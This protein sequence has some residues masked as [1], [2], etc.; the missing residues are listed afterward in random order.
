MA[1][2][3][4]LRSANA[5]AAE[6]AHEPHVITYDMPRLVIGRG[7]GCDL[8]L[9]DLSVSH[10]HASIRQRGTEYI[11]MDEGSTNGTFIGSVRLPPQSPRVLR[12]GEL[13]RL[14]RVWLEVRVEYSP[15]SVQTAQAT[16]ELALALV[17]Q[18][19]D[20]QGRDAGPRLVVVDGP[21]AGKQLD[22]RDGNEQVVLGR[23]RDV[24][25]ELDVAEASRR[26]A[27]VVRHG[28]HVMLRD[29]GSRIGTSARGEMV[30]TD[31]D[32][33]LRPGDDFSIGPDVIR[34]EFQAVE[35]LRELERADDEKMAASE[36]VPP[37]IQGS[38]SPPAEP[39]QPAAPSHAWSTA[40]EVQPAQPRQPPA[41]PKRRA[42]HHD[43][44]WGKT[45]VII[46]LLALAVLGM[47]AVGLVWLFRGL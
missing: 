46:V 7:E 17:S 27:G 9:P 20:A 30:A 13:I 24:N 3:L 16:K 26:H 11:V 37:P 1:V 36:T 5:S 10:R 31:K 18:A 35:A 40:P 42:A 4:V 41:P 25:L 12:N 28:D 21:D 2:S 8:R 23:G 44:G 43:G 39:S 22:L 33:V 6:A 32:T 38:A 14:G 19:L 29:L 15:V 45:D 47:S 34:F